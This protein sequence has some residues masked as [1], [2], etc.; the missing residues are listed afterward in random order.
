MSEWIKCG[1]RLPDEDKSV[2]VLQDGNDV[3]EYLVIQAAIFEGQFYA[4]HL[5]GLIDYDDLWTVEL[6]QPLPLPPSL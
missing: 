3:C 5:N 6:W 2:L 4:D 1:E